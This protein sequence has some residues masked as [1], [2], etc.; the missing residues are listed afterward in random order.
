MYRKYF[1]LNEMPF[2]ISPDPK[3]LYMSKHHR[4]AL[5]HLLYGAKS[6]GG[7]VLLTGDVGTG[8]TTIC[9]CFLEQLPEK[10]NVAF[11][12]NPM[13]SV[14][15]MLKYICDE[16]NIRYPESGSIKEL[17][18]CINEYLINSFRRGEKTVLVIEEAQDLSLN[19]LE[20]IRLLTNLETNK[21]KLLQ[22]VMIGQPELRDIL[23][24]DN[25][26]QLSQ[27]ITARYHI[28]PLFK[29]EIFDYIKHRLRVAGTNSILFP[30][31]LV[32][33]IYKYSKGI[34]RLIN[35]I[36]D[37]ALLGAYVEGKQKVDKD[38]LLKA[39]NEVLG[40]SEL[41]SKI[42]VTKRTIVYS[43][44]FIVII[45]VL[46]LVFFYSRGVS[47]KPALKFS[48][49]N[50]GV[51]KK[52]VFAD[53]L[54]EIKRDGRISK[55]KEKAN[56]RLLKEWGVSTTLIDGNFCTNIKNKGLQCLEG[57][58]SM[59]DI[60]GFNL[61]VV[62]KIYDNNNVSHYVT[63]LSI[64]GDVGEIYY[65][66]KMLNVRMKE[67]EDLWRG[68]YFILWKSP[69]YYNGPFRKGYKGNI[70]LWLRDSL[71]KIFGYDI[72]TKSDVYD[73]ALS[74]RIKRFQVGEGLTPDGIVGAQTLI[75]INNLLNIN[76]VK[77]IKQREG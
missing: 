57:I 33:I 52:D 22:I 39:I 31:S 45:F 23:S 24:R 41:K 65:N 66:E 27:R 17:V 73:D 10:T 16:L 2:S 54:S 9:R 68:E 36:C 51:V 63:L 19:V 7:F 74:N 49:N 53:I 6:E 4:E 30:E 34:P 48:I 76:D 26:V 14:L 21:Y 11:I 20:Q 47:S 42:I 71:K 13:V 55:S 5:A 60:I 69:P 25:M 35:M 29:D 12:L 64:N 77:L 67:L 72:D 44:S 62:L 46:L 75:H 28:R 40:I 15:E 43:L 37:R 32:G 18:D 58:G 3:F 59:Q 38:I 1:G 8:K 61:P 70:V 56:Q 50:T